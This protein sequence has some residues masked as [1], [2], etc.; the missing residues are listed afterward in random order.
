M[1]ASNAWIITQAGVLVIRPADGGALR[2]VTR[3]TLLRL[4]QDLGLAVE[5]RPFSRAE[6]LAAREAFVNAATTLVA[7][8]V[9]IDGAPVGDGAPGQLT[10]ELR[11]R[12]HGV[13]EMTPRSP[14][15]IGREA[16]P[17]HNSCITLAIQYVPLCNH[18]TGRA[19]SAS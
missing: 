1:G 2:G 18:R 19:F 15:G 11:R 7:P 5:E 14:N 6:A 4:A 16:F 10:L 8:V 9:R 13:A 12:L 3:G 17:P